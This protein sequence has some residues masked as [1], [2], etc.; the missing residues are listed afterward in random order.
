[1]KKATPANQPSSNDKASHENQI[2][3][4]SDY[5]APDF[6]SEE[7]M[8]FGALCNGTRS[9]GRKTAVGAP[10]FCNANKINS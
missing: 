1:M 8:A 3:S 4:E 5:V 2:N 7:L 10:N 9:G 6:I